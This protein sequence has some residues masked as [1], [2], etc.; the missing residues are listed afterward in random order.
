[1]N[2]DARF[3][4]VSAIEQANRN[5]TERLRARNETLAR[6]LRERK[7]AIADA[8]ESREEHK[9]VVQA[10]KAQAKRKPDV[11]N[12]DDDEQLV[13]VVLPRRNTGI[14]RAHDGVVQT[15]TYIGAGVFE[16]SV[17][18]RET[19]VHGDPTAK[20]AARQATREIT[21]R[22]EK[23]EAKAHARRQ[24]RR[25]FHAKRARRE[26]KQRIATLAR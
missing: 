24:A 1:M 9:R 23:R 26:A 25:S 16:I 7:Q 4:G 17:D 12:R 20:A 8:Q 22:T 6:E 11:F 2:T 10:R 21:A 3:P 14:I 5:R 13:R 19:G 18:G 15:E